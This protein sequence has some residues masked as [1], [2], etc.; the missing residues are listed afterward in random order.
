MPVSRLDPKIKFYS[1]V[2]VIKSVKYKIKRSFFRGEFS[3]KIDKVLFTLK[4]RQELQ[5]AHKIDV[6]GQSAI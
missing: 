4:I 5:G 3:T 1:L 6:S 2:D